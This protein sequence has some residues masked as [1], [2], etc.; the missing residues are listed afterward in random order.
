MDFVL[1]RLK[2][3]NRWF[4]LVPLVLSG[5]WFSI[6]EIKILDP[7]YL[8]YIKLDDYIPYVPLFVIPYVFWYF[9]VAAPAIYL[10]FQAPNDFVRM[11]IFLTI[12]MVIACTAYTLFPNGQVLRPVLTGYDEPLIR[13][14][15]FIYSNDTPTNSAPSIHVIYSVAAHSAVAYYIMS[16]NRFIWVK[17]LSL[18]VSALCII[19]TVFIKQH[20]LIDLILGLAVSGLLYFLLYKL[21]VKKPKRGEDVV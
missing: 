15:R 4:I 1:T 2:P 9:Y 16:I 21:K 19:S 18:F 5:V 3:Y 8:L 6:L 12:G 17:W 11:A 7:E 20:S 14:I 13:L 10:F